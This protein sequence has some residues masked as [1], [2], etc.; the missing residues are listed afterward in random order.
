MSLVFE[1]DVEDW[2]SPAGVE[3]NQE[4]IFSLGDIT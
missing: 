2:P 4:S 1:R 3:A